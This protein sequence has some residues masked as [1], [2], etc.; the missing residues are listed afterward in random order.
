[1]ALPESLR[2][3]VELSLADGRQL[4]AGVFDFL[5]YGEEML[6]GFCEAVGAVF[7]RP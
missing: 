6:Y 7:E 5:D 2:E 4:D 3:T 1:M